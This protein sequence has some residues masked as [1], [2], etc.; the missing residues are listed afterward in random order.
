[1]HAVPQWMKI[2]YN[3][4]YSEQFWELSSVLLQMTNE[5]LCLTLL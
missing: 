3:A 1:M 2:L 4:R 5:N